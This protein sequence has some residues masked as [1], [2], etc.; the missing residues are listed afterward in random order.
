MIDNRHMR[1]YKFQRLAIK[2]SEQAKMSNKMSK[3]YFTLAEL[4]DG[5][6]RAQFGDYDRNVVLAEMYDMRELSYMPIGRLQIVTSGDKQADI[7]QALAKLA[8]DDNS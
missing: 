2:P 7:E 8:I 4:I 5:R 6:W 3:R 1:A